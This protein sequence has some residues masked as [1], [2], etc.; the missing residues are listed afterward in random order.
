M[1]HLPLVLSRSTGSLPVPSSSNISSFDARSIGNRV[2]HSASR[3]SQP[4]ASPSPALTKV[5]LDLLGIDSL[6]PVALTR[7]QT[8]VCWRQHVARGARLLRNLL[9]P[10]RRFPPSPFLS[11]PSLHAHLV[12]R[13]GQTPLLCVSCVSFGQPSLLC[14]SCVFSGQHTLHMRTLCVAS[15]P[16]LRMMRPTP[17]GSDDTC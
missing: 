8:T 4:V 1:L 16:A 6:G 9:H 5:P 13:D 2:H 15:A 17:I 7:L 3:G 12:S 14:T 10:L 11:Q